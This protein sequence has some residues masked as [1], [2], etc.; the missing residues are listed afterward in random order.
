MTNISLLEESGFPPFHATAL[1][2]NL[3][4]FESLK[5]Y[6]PRKYKLKILRIVMIFCPSWLYKS[7]KR[8]MKE[9]VIRLSVLNPDLLSINYM[10]FL[11]VSVVEDA[12]MAK[13]TPQII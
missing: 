5:M 9:N 6:V 2:E 10:T 12:T 13:A 4:K 1:V 11:V 8:L 7:H 3:G